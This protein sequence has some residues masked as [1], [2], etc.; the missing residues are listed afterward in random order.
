MLILPS[1]IRSRARTS[2]AH[3][4]GTLGNLPRTPHCIRG[5]CTACWVSSAGLELPSTS[6]GHITYQG[7]IV[8]PA[9]AK[10][11]AEWKN[12]LTNNRIAPG[13]GEVAESAPHAN[14]VSSHVDVKEWKPT[15]QWR[16][17]PWWCPN[18]EN[19]PIWAIPITKGMPV[20]MLT[21]L[22]GLQ[23]TAVRFV[24]EHMKA[25]ARPDTS[26]PRWILSRHAVVE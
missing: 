4:W 26:Q 19:I 21:L 20:R 8:I 11:D 12:R 13:D 15:G 14:G 7:K 18:T 25:A 5:S 16:W 2:E 3:R 22:P 17:T 10:V 6:P 23:S 1:G 24:L 9:V